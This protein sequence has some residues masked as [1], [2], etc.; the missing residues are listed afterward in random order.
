MTVSAPALAILSGADSHHCTMV[1]DI[2][3]Q[4][5]GRGVCTGSGRHGLFFLCRWCDVFV[6]SVRFVSSVCF[7]VG[8]FC[9]GASGDSSPINKVTA[10]VSQP[11]Q[12]PLIKRLLPNTIFQWVKIFAQKAD[13][14]IGRR[15]APVE[16]YEGIGR[17]DPGGTYIH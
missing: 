5:M 7:C 2:P 11:L 10:G 8:C 13:W 4:V 14:V 9:G 1:E 12:P 15:E 3:L 16:S 6:G 17:R